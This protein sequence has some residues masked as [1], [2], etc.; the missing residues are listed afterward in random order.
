MEFIAAEAVLKVLKEQGAD[1]IFGYPGATTAPIY[2]HL[3]NSGLR[4]VLTRNEQ[5]AAHAA[6]AYAVAKGTVGVCIVTSGPG[7]TNLL[8]GIA[9]AYMDSVPLVAICGQVACWQVGTDSF[10]EVD[11]TGVSTPITKH[12]YLVKHASELI[13]TLR[14]AFLI[15]KSGRPGPVVVD[16]PLDVQKEILSEFPLPEETALRS[17]KAA[18]AIKKRELNRFVRALSR[19]KKP[20]FVVGGGVLKSGASKELIALSETLGVPVV[21]TMMGLTAMPGDHPQFLGMLGRHGTKAA[22]NAFSESDLVAFIGSR[23]S[24]RTVADLDAL[25]QRASI[26]HIDI[27]PAEI[28]KNVAAD[29]S[30]VGDCKQILSAISLVAEEL[31]C[32]AGWLSSCCEAKKNEPRANSSRFVSPAAFLEELSK[33]APSDTLITT[34]VGQHQIWTAKHFCFR[35]PNSLLTS[36]GFGTMGFGLPAAIGAKIA[37]GERT[38]IAIEGDGSFQMAM[39]ELATMKQEGIA[40]KIVLFSNRSLG[41]VREY[42]TLYYHANYVGVDLGA[43]PHFDKIAE[44]YDIS[45]RRINSDSEIGSAID[46]ML[47]S[48]HSYL[49]EIVTDES[50][51]TF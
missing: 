42:Q 28:N 36:G 44:A 5:G 20:L 23:I 9:N 49:L 2:D 27:D 15:A 46:E 37:C 47:S 25:K 32:P 51:T 39:P 35:S 48:P 26:V 8:S 24:D 10:Q 31:R 16:I 6:A 13:G 41:L 34:E 11:T 12:N 40:L 1:V 43:Y 30:L 33:Q 45:Y 22:A 7:V 17:Q 3:P 18:P 50:E 4:H 14:E 38:V 29:I 19:A 21:S